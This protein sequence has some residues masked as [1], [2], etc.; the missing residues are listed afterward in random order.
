MSK[1][2]K[3]R[4]KESTELESRKEA[5]FALAVKVRGLF[6]LKEL[7]KAC[8]ST[9]DELFRLCDFVVK[10][11][12]TQN[13]RGSQLTREAYAFKDNN[14]PVLGVAHCDTVAQGTK[15]RIIKL[16]TSDKHGENLFVFNP[17]L[18]DRLGVYTL[19]YLLPKFGIKLDILLTENEEVGYSTARYFSKPNG[20]EWNWIVQFD[21]AGADSVKYQY[22]SIH[23]AE[24]IFGKLNGG[25]YT[26]IKDLENLG[27]NAMNIGIAYGNNHSD[28][29]W[30]DLQTYC[31]Q[32]AKFIYFYK[33][34][35]L[36]LSKYEKPKV[37][38]HSRHL[39]VHNHN[40][41]GGYWNEFGF[42][43]GCNG[44]VHKN[45]VTRKKIDAFCAACK[46]PILKEKTHQID[47]RLIAC[48]NCDG[49][50][51]ITRKLEYAHF[52]DKCGS[53]VLAYTDNYVEDNYGWC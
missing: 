9:I 47:E 24:E 7:Q 31:Y 34:N 21:R 3:K 40:F 23:N 26:C 45:K 41:V 20:K 52:C 28:D 36:K 17:R 6:D 33:E 32:I 4:K 13:H 51:E 53:H 48:P 1:I 30:F 5:I 15:T 16:K 25:S 29:A 43:K 2:G 38:P 8:N 27:L 49:V 42:C 46:E 14:A 11:K 19:M 39:N 44:T 50:V 12:K 10:Q 18:D 37:I 35:K 22:Q